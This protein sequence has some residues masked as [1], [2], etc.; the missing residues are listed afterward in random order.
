M[1]IGSGSSSPRLRLQAGDDR[2]VPVSDKRAGEATQIDTNHDGVCSDPEIEA[3]LRSRNEIRAHARADV[4]AIV[5]EYKNHLLDRAHPQESEYRSL[6]QINQEMQQLAQDHPDRVQ[7]QS[8]AKTSEGRD[9]W[10]MKVTSDAQ[11]DTSNKPGVVITGTH[12]AREWMTPEVTLQLA[13]D[14][15]NNYDN[16]PDAR[17]RLDNAELWF[18]PVVNP[19]G[20]QYT[21]TDDSW[22]RKNRAPITDGPG[23][24]PTRKRGSVGVD[25]NRNYWDG[26][27]DHMNLFRREGDT[28]TSTWDDYGASDDPDDDT[29]RGKPGSEPEVQGLMKLEYQRPNIHGVLDHHSYG[30][31]LLRPWGHIPDAPAEVA[32]YDE[33]AARMVKAQGDQAYEYMQSFEDY[34]TYG[35]SETCHEA[36]G[37]LN[38]TIE[39][40]RSFQ[41]SYSEFQTTYKAVSSADLAFVDYIIEKHPATPPAP[42]PDPAPSPEPNPAPAPDPEPA[43]APDPEPAPAPGPDPAPNPAP[44]PP[45]CPAPVRA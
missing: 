41:P 8:I 15:V 27:P 23:V 7:L 39:M 45:P 14:L 43:P 1:Q 16:D 19:D 44:A 22:W 26:N 10:A 42:P 4:P 17:R 37:K 9:V 33:V 30:E 40:G 36:N 11:G 35:S 34:P 20:F 29:Y 2:T 28:P 5:E 24:D 3:W 32:D 13:E 12:H 21:R 38:F 6:D 31:Q 18:I 25:L